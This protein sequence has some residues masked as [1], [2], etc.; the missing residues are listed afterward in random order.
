MPVVKIPTPLREYVDEQDEIDVDGETV[1]EALRA[2]TDEYNELSE[3]LYK[4]NG[5][6]L[7]QYVNI[8]VNEEDIRTQNDAQTQLDEDDVISIV[9]AIAGGVETT[10]STAE[11]LKEKGAEEIET[12]LTKEEVERYS[13]HFLV[14]EIGEEGQK[15]LKSSSILMVGAGGLGAPFGMYVAAAGIGKLGI[16][17]HDK[18][19]LSNLQRQLLHGQSDIGRS[20]LDSAKESIHEIN[21]NVELELYEEK[22][23]S[24]NALDIIDQY[25]VVVDGTDNFPTRYLVNDACVMLGKPNIY[26][27][28]FRFEGQVSVFDA[29]KGP[30]YRCLYEEP[31]PP[32]LVPDCAEGG[33]L[34]VLPGIVGSLQAL[35]A[36][37]VITGIGEPLIGRYLIFDAKTMNFR[38][39]KLPKNP[40]CP[41]C[42]EDPEVTELIDY[43]Q[44]CGIDLSEEEEEALREDDDEDRPPEMD[45]TTLKERIDAEDEPFILDV[46]SPQE[47]EICRLEGSTVIPVG[48]LPEHL[49]ELPR[50]EEIVVHCRSGQRSAQAQKLLLE[51]GFED[52]KNL[53]GGILA[54]AHEIDDTMP[55]Y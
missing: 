53:K 31:P 52:V 27:S 28:I 5:D 7:R 39:L 37:K 36:I 54:W 50:D 44:F 3:H 43:K 41:V 4:E 49:D 21:P 11:E 34:G 33:V 12:E 13:R 20:K 16:I 45:V 29:E 40:D 26:G 8:Y 46:R 48:D 2:L 10:K 15:K 35:E 17:D 1:D 30:C 14:P 42:G 25:D 38:E 23:T 9:P 55:T 19:E 18:V 22:L 24:D 32:G 51:E 47:V 6:S